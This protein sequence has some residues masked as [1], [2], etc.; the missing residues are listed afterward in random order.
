[1]HFGEIQHVASAIL[2]DDF[3]NQYGRVR[4]ADGDFINAGQEVADRLECVLSQQLQL[5][6][7]PV[8]PGTDCDG[9]GFETWI[10]V[11][12]QQ[13]RRDG[14]HPP[15]AE[16]GDHADDQKGSGGDGELDE[17]LTARA[18]YPYRYFRS[19][20]DGY[21]TWQLISGHLSVPRKDFNWLRT[22]K[23]PD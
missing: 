7:T 2:Y 21:V 6:D 19:G 12:D 17:K 10:P 11:N 23:L 16:D 8:V 5:D 3:V 1:M 4:R 15:P 9:L 13:Y 18:P 14:G 20:L 22:C